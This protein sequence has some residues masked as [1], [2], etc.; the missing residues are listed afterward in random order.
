MDFQDQV[1]SI[2][3]G[4][5]IISSDIL[6]DKSL[7]ELWCFEGLFKKSQTDGILYWQIGFNS[8]NEEIIT[9]HGYY[10]TSGG[11]YGKLQEDRLSVSENLS[12]RNIQE[13]GLL[14]SRSKYIDKRR[15]GYV[16]ASEYGQSKELSIPE[17]QLANKYD[18][19]T[20][21][22]ITEEHLKRG[23]T[24]QPKLDGIRARIFKINGDIIIYSRNN[25][26]YPYL[27]EVRKEA[28]LV[29]RLLPQG[30]G[31]DCE[32]YNSDLTFEELTSII[33]TEKFMHQKNNLIKCYIFD[34]IMLNTC[35]EDRTRTLREAYLKVKSTHTF[36]HLF[37]LLQ[38]EV[39]L[40][41]LIKDIHD[42][43][44]LAGYEGAII[45]KLCG[46]TMVAKDKK[47][48]YYLPG[49]NNN[50]L[51]VKIFIDEEGTVIGA[52]EGE[53]RETGLVIWVIR[54]DNGKVFDCRP[55]GSFDLR[56]Y[57][58]DHYKDYVGKRYTYRY[59]EK[60][61]YDIPRFPIGVGFRDY[62]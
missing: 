31:L 21:K 12:G 53:G 48:S 56:R 30:T 11:N 61:E 39:H 28:E 41:S 52:K 18:L 10:L 19:N 54:D 45:R 3:G 50:L 23:I 57:H 27:N 7:P 43:Y 38:E 55:R 6:Y 40:R 17:A 62:E 60:T 9:L 25:L 2:F 51:K 58:Y 35:V 42:K 34:I 59:F 1:K 32:L 46:G 5:V 26:E 22:P 33:R 24:M 4:Y 36:T 37:V 15:E 13:Q 14:Q 47:E 44:V 29:L 16:P 8:L 20:G 49:R